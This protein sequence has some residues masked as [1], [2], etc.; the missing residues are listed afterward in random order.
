MSVSVF[1]AQSNALHQAAVWP[2]DSKAND[3]SSGR[4]DCATL[5]QLLQVAI[6][7]KFICHGGIAA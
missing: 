2:Q 5:D 4:P 6:Q 1:Q 3:C 7:H